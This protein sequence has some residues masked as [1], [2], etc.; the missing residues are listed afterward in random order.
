MRLLHAGDIAAL[1]G[2]HPGINPRAARGRAIVFQALE[3][4]H[5]LAVGDGV[6]VDLLHDLVDYRL[7]VR[8][9]G[10]IV[11]GDG[12][13]RFV[14]RIGIG[15]GEFAQAPAKMEDEVGL[16]ARIARGFDRLFVVLQEAL[17]IGE[18]TFLFDVN[19]GGK[20]EDFGGD[21]L[22]LELAAIDL[23]R[24]I[25]EGC[26][27]S[28]HVVAH[29]Q[30]LEFRE[31]LALHARIGR[32][33]GGVLAHEEHALDL[34]LHHVDGE[35]EM[36]VVAGDARQIVES[37]VVFFVR[38]IAVVGLHQADE[39]CGELVPHP[40][41]GRVFVEI[42]LA[43]LCRPPRSGAWADSR[44]GCRRAWGCRSSPGC[45]RVRAGRECRRRDARYCRA[46]V[47]GWRRCG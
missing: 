1:F 15:G 11:P 44:A 10:R 29:H 17:R 42:G 9:F 39:V 18:S 2:I 35:A 6:A 23:G 36:G 37:P 31:R 40:C 33:H 26:R 24:V 12:A 47:A 19:G 21:V 8:P 7:F 43:G 45:W 16:A 34:A 22:G 25:P 20:E 28:L 30:P 38:A 14:N 3:I 5:Q 4:F 32:A 13:Q 46:A 27:F 41:A